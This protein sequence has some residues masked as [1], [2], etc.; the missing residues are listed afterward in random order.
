MTIELSVNRWLRFTGFRL[1]VVVDDDDEPT[2]F[3]V[4]WYGWPGSKGWRRIEGT[5]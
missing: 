4:G 5:A 1:F 3:G 2:G